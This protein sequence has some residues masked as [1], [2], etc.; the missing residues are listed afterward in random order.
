M[1]EFGHATPDLLKLDVEGAEYEALKSLLE[2]AVLPRILMIDF[3]VPVSPAR[4]HGAVQQLR[5]R[6]YSLVAIELLNYTFV[7][8]ADSPGVTK[9]A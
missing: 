2:K 1:A 6:G 9:S 3:D 7:R 5:Q 4:I 8:L